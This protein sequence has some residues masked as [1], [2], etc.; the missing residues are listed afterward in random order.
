MSNRAKNKDLDVIE[1]KINCSFC[2]NYIGHI[3]VKEGTGEKKLF[4][5]LKILNKSSILVC[6]DCWIQNELAMSP[7]SNDVRRNA[8]TAGK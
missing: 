7:V 1:Q 6:P 4:H 5:S 2:G 8:R 3:I